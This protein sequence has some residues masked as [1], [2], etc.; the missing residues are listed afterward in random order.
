M[1]WQDVRVYGA[2]QGPKPM[3]PKEWSSAR[4]AD[5]YSGDPDEQLLGSAAARTCTR[6]SGQALRYDAY[7][8]PGPA[9]CAYMVRTAAA[10]WWS[11]LAASPPC[12]ALLCPCVP[13]RPP[14]PGPCLQPATGRK[15]ASRGSAFPPP[16]PHL[17]LPP[18]PP[19]R[20]EALPGT[21]WH[22]T[23]HHHTRESPYP[24]PPPPLPACRPA[25]RCR[26]PKSFTGRQASRTC[27]QRLHVLHT[28][29]GHAA[30]TAA[31]DP[32]QGGA[33][34]APLNNM[35]AS[36]R[37]GGGRRPGGRG[38]RARGEGEVREGGVHACVR[39]MRVCSCACACVAFACTYVWRG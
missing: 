30:T 37:G 14:P 21:P 25:G 15:P 39:G 20:T 28:G 36:V 24:F 5:L 34:G 31:V 6:D 17:T 2:E 11:P 18:P 38:A 4:R 3:H 7:D 35:Q 8:A 22:I 29:Q 10:C 26:R 23:H 33:G 9:T 12:L 13:L 19:L 27:S 32:Q 1:V 16:L